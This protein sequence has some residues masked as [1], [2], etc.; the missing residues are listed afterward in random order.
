MMTVYELG[1]PIG[2]ARTHK[3]CRANLDEALGQVEQLVRAGWGLAAP[4]PA[5]EAIYAV[6]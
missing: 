1:R 5:E 2:T 4:A 3:R 6:R